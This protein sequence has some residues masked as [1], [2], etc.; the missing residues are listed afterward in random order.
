[1]QLP[2]TILTKLN[3]LIVDTLF[4]GAASNFLCWKVSLGR[5]FQIPGCQ[6]IR[7]TNKHDLLYE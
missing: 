4:R 7:L 3:I 6:I 2:P 1:M 5:N